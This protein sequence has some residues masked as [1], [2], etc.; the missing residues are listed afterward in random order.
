[1]FS[2]MKRLSEIKNKKA[3]TFI[4][5]LIFQQISLVLT[6]SNVD[7][8]LEIRKDIEQ[9]LPAFVEGE[10]FGLKSYS[11][12]PHY[13]LKIE[14]WQV[15]TN[16][17]PS[18]IMTDGI[19]S[20]IFLTHFIKKHN[21]A[22]ALA[23]AS[24]I[25]QIYIEEAGMEGV[26]HDIAFSQMCLETGFLKFNGINKKEQNN[27]CGL[28]AINA[29]TEGEYFRTPRIGIRAHIQH[30][31]AYAGKAA[32]NNQLVDNRFDLVKRGEASSVDE[33]TGKWATDKD[34]GTKINQLLTRLYDL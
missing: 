6:Y 26:N 27:F 9:T 4:C 24:N 16:D 33:L 29:T 2:L 15:S 10:R 11:L 7:A 14:K 18:E 17:L 22:I 25:A 34:Y 5:M 8:N 3:F 20:E 12:H 32:L 31:K 30:L 19:R 23:E 1:M 21:P 28:G 13:Q